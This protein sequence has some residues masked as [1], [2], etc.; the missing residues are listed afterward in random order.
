M[1]EEK[2]LPETISIE[3]GFEI[4]LKFHIELREKNAE[5]EAALLEADKGLEFYGNEDHWSKPYVRQGGIGYQVKRD[6]HLVGWKRARETRQKIE[7]LVNEI[8]ERK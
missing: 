3:M 8:K 1:S 6:L 2:E 7:K 4:L 5:L